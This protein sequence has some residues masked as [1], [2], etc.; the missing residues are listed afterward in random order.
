MK[1]IDISLY[2]PLWG[3]CIVKPREVEETDPALARAKKAGI[4]LPEKERHREQMAQVTG[5]LVAVGGDCFPDW[6]VK[7]E[8]GDLV[9]FNKHAGFVLD[10]GKHRT[11]V[12]TDIMIRIREKSND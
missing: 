2:D 7:P 5:T 9:V 12:D 10:D 6:K 4:V 1:G 8:V 3:N 11:V